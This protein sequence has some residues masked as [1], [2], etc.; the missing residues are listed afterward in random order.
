MDRRRTL[1]FVLPLAGLAITASELF[2]LIDARRAVEACLERAQ[3]EQISCDP[4]P[5]LLFV[6]VAVAFG[7]LFAARLAYLVYKYVRSGR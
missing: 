5:D 1:S 2:R 3:T 6:V 4:P 7:L